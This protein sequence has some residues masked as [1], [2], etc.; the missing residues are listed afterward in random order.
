MAAPCPWGRCGCVRVLLCPC[1]CR[2][3]CR[4]P[5]Q[6]VAGNAN[7]RRCSF[8]VAA[9]RVLAAVGVAEMEQGEAEERGM[10][11]VGSCWPLGRA[12]CPL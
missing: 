3:Q 11:P 5:A 7:A 12:G 4:D 8:A 2:L 1:G 9:S 6:A 10:E